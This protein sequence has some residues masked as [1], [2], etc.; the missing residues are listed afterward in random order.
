LCF[1][2]EA[3]GWWGEVV[4]TEGRRSMSWAHECARI[5]CETRANAVR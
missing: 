2:R 5:A 1:N 4:M 3:N